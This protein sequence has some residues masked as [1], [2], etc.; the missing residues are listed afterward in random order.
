[1]DNAGRDTDAMIREPEADLVKLWHS[2]SNNNYISLG[3]NEK[4]S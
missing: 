1:M 4:H 3:M 2:K